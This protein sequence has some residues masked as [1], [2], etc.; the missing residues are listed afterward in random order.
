MN[1][2]SL[3]VGVKGVFLRSFTCYSGHKASLDYIFPCSLFSSP[4]CLAIG[5]HTYRNVDYSPKISLIIKYY[6]IIWKVCVLSGHSIRNRT[7]NF[8]KI[9]N[10]SFRV[11]KKGHCCFKSCFKYMYQEDN[12]CLNILAQTWKQ[13][14]NSRSI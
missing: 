13:I 9:F 10:T 3:T 1:S 8:I 7:G 14:S 6:S 12:S 2:K 11:C 4:S 5:K